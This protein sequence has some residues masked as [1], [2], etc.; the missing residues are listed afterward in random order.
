M[1]ITTESQYII[2]VKQ[3]GGSAGQSTISF[4]NARNGDRLH[5]QTASDE[6][7]TNLGNEKQWPNGFKNLDI[8]DIT[9]TGIKTGNTTHTVNTSIRGGGRVT[10]TMTDVSTANA[11]SIS[12]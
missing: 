1:P 10:L 7:K 2:S 3:T 6:A 11:P 12:F 8:I 4:I 5:I 9:G